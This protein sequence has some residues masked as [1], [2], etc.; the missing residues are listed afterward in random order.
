MQIP[1][2]IMLIIFSLCSDKVNKP[3]NVTLRSLVIL[4]SSIGTTDMASFSCGS[5][6]SIP[7]SLFG[8]LVSSSQVEAALYRVESSAYITTLATFIAE[9][10]SLVNIENRSGPRQLPC[11]IPQFM[12]LLSEKLLLKKTLC[13]L[14][15]R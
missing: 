1:F 14:L 12:F 5:Q 3:S 13:D 9:G 2:P 8:T 11:G 7:N 4:T 6:A 15:D 10:K